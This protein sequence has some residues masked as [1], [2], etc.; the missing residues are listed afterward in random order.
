MQNL[1]KFTQT[2][3]G[4][5]STPKNLA[6]GGTLTVT[7]A[8]ALAGA[9][10]ISNSTASTTSTTGALKVA[11]GVGV[12]GAVNVG[13]TLTV[14]TNLTQ[15]GGIR[16]NGSFVSATTGSGNVM[17][18]AVTSIEKVYADDGGVA[19]TS[20]NLRVSLSRFLID[21]AVTA[22]SFTMRGKMGQVKIDASVVSSGHIAGVE[23]YV[24]SSASGTFGSTATGLRGVVDVPSGGVIGANVFV[25]G[26][27]AYSV[28]LAG[29]HT[30][31]A[32]AFDVPTPGAGTWDALMHIGPT[33]G[34]TA[35]GSTKTTVTGVDNWLK[36]YIDGT[37]NYV[38]C[39]TS[40]TA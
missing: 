35:A 9:V 5:I 4:N 36:V 32:V 15:T 31:K 30:G 33:S 40:T 39:Y 18:S 21:T 24:E 10:V 22:G 2:A 37:V 25:S 34:T 8:Q 20:G 7:G 19:L 11:G 26:V 14:A 29:T 28:D 3:A 12:A 17:S 13:T 6:V 23:G 1:T 38:P 16:S 27:M